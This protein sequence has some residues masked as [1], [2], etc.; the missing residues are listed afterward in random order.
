MALVGIFIYLFMFLFYYSRLFD[1]P[2]S[3]I[4]SVS[5]FMI[6]LCFFLCLLKA[7]WFIFDCFKF[8]FDFAS[9]GDVIKYMYTVESPVHSS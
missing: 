5:I 2:W 7:I 4:I 3:K 6:Y 9:I 8:V 1:L